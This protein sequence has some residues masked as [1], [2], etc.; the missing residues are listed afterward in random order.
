MLNSWTILVLDK[1]ETEYEIKMNN[2]YLHVETSAYFCL[3][4]L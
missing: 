2:V 3:N 4:S 1:R